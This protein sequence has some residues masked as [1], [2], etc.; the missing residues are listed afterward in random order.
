M[1]TVT[2][3]RRWEARTRLTNQHMKHTHMPSTGKEPTTLVRGPLRRS[4]DT[5]LKFVLS[6]GAQADATCAISVQSGDHDTGCSGVT[7]RAS[8]Y[9]ER[10]SM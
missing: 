1:M 5:I 9:T 6:T 8:K 4:C 3:L 10:N 2:H 7:S